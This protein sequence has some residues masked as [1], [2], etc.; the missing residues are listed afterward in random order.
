[1]TSE[2]HCSKQFHCSDNL[3]S[4]KTH[5]K[6]ESPEALQVDRAKNM[7]ERINETKTCFD[8][9]ATLKL[10]SVQNS[11]WSLCC[12]IYV[13]LIQIEVT[14]KQISSIKKMPLSDCPLDVSFLMND[15]G[16]YIQRTCLGQVVLGCLSKQ[17]EQ[18]ALVHGVCL[19]S[20]LS[21]RPLRRT[22][23]EPTQ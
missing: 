14:W 18:A 3:C 7:S 22:I 19:C 6:D 2:F 4:P 23:G 10:K 21:P 15:V 17:A 12:L 1:M 9:K 13:N 11:K 5:C 8:F 20:C 16:I